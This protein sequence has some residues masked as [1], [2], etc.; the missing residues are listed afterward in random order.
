MKYFCGTKAGGLGLVQ[1]KWS[2]GRK[3]GYTLFFYKTA[4]NL[5]EP[6]DVL[7]L[8]HTFS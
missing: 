1:F 3:E 4:Y 6:E 7:I 5:A 2:V 8:A